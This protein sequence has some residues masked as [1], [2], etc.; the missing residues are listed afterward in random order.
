MP[1]RIMYKHP[2]S[3]Q[4]SDWSKRAPRMGTRELMFSVV[5]P[6]ATADTGSLLRQRLS[7][8]HLTMN[9]SRR[10]QKCVLLSQPCCNYQLPVA[11]ATTTMI[12]ML[13][14]RYSSTTLIVVIVMMM[15]I[16]Y[17]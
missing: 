16:L 5:V 3:Q 7:F 1:S 2:S 15:T 14:R 11:T 12:Q 10:P 13:M 6:T 8:R 4:D 9:K 17:Q